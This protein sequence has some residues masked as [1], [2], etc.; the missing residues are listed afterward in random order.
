M[1]G[2]VRRATALALETISSDEATVL[3]VIRI[4]DLTTNG[5]ALAAELRARAAA[6]RQQALDAEPG[7]GGGFDIAEGVFNAF[8]LRQKVYNDGMREL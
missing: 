8:G 1:E 6:L 7:E 2:D 5:P 3:R 4:A